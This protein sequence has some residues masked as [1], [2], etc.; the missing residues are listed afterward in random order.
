MFNFDSGKIPMVGGPID[1]AFYIFP[2]PEDKA[3]IA[4]YHVNPDWDETCRWAT[5]QYEDGRYIFI[6]YE[7]HP[8]F[9]T[10]AG[11]EP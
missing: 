5:Y 8:E 3:Y 1:G 11:A 7:Y 2:C 9:S 10:K 4:R 6:G